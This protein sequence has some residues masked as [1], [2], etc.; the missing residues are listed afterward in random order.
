M[1]RPDNEVQRRSDFR[2]QATYPI[3]YREVGDEE[4]TGRWTIA[5]TRDLSG[6]GA[7][8]ELVDDGK[9]EWSV[10]DLVEAQVIVPPKPVF[11]IGKIVRL[12][13]DERGKACAG[14]MFVSISP[15]DKDRIVRA[16]L[17][18]GLRRPW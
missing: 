12:F 16:V 8:F 9:H 14:V 10:G 13:Q 17:D 1:S 4:E 7:S 2:S 18:E 6:G 5:S 11:A 3:W 15:A